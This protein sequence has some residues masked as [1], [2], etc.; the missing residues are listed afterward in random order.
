[1]RAMENSAD[2]HR[3]VHQ[4]NAVVPLSSMTEKVR[5]IF[6]RSGQL[7]SRFADEAGEMYFND[8]EDAPVLSAGHATWAMANPYDNPFVPGNLQVTLDNLSIEYRAPA[9]TLWSVGILMVWVDLVKFYRRGFLMVDE[10]R[11]VEYA[12]GTQFSRFM[13]YGMETACEKATVVVRKIKLKLHGLGVPD[14]KPTLVLDV[15]NSRLDRQK[16]RTN[17][18][19]RAAEKEKEES[20]QLDVESIPDKELRESM[21]PAALKAQFT[22]T[23]RHMQKPEVL[24]ELLCMEGDANCRG[25]ELGFAIKSLDDLVRLFHVATLEEKSLED[26][27]D[28][29]GVAKNDDEVGMVDDKEDEKKH[30]SSDASTEVD[31]ASSEE[32]EATG[33]RPVHRRQLRGDVD[34]S[35]DFASDVEQHVRPRFGRVAAHTDAPAEQ[36][37]RARSPRSV[38]DAWE[39]K[40]GLKFLSLFNRLASSSSEVKRE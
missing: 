36:P 24:R 20:R 1:M 26:N 7:A 12:S 15:F 39:A 27:G 37:L 3:L 5:K 21:R 4:G 29:A 13:Q 31:G 10:K 6:E 9:P 32:E 16:W 8:I 40:T 17:L 28:E 22:K 38:D 2:L 23:V 30:F 18:E 25:P 33:I 34:S 19:H 11:E 14:D 35:E